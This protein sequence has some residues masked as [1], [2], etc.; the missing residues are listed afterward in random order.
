MTNG[1]QQWDEGLVGPARIIAELDHSPI[2]V[3]A[4]PGTGKTYSLMR[5]LARLLQQG[6]DADRIFV[7]TFTR[8]SARDLQSE[9]SRL[10]INDAND[11]HAGTLHSHCFRILSRTDVLDLTGRVPRPLLDYEQRF[12]IADMRERQFGGIRDKDRRLQ[13]FNA[14]WARLQTDQPGWPEDRI[15][16]LFHSSLLAWLRFHQALLI[17]ELIPETLRYLRDNPACP[18][19]N[20]FDHVL[21]DE[22]Q[23]LNRAEQ[24]LLDL[25]SENGSLVV[26]GDENQSIYSFKFAHPEGVSNFDETHSNTHDEDLEECRRCPCLVVNL[27]NSLI[28]HNANR[29]ERELTT[30]GDNPEGEVHVVQWQ[31]MD[32]EAK[33]LAEFIQQ[34]ILN[35]STIPGQILVLAPRRQFGYAIR[36][37]LNEL[38]IPA[39][40]FFH[41][42]ALEGNP[43]IL[44]NCEAQQAYTLLTLLANPDD[45]VA[46]RC[47]C[48]F[49]SASLR[50]GGWRSIRGYCEEHNQSPWVL[51]LLTISLTSQ[52]NSII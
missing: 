35:G 45:R 8:T 48:G 41:E 12:L 23:D 15:D 7:C 14:A 24:T 16:Q 50:N 2:R 21:V 39:H 17:G 30:C 33:G 13:A 43:R 32:D 44:D 3:L 38:D 37:E 51:R 25:L 10:G 47:W 40:S 27:A 9:V 4:G 31:S 28:A 5:R 52:K 20:A 49:G 42:E 22:Y 18:D 6:E 46:L 34:R 19:R 26:I 1:N 29:E 36:D 11:V